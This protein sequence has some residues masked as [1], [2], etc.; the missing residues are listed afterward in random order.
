MARNCFM[1]FAWRHNLIY[2][3]FLLLWILLRRANTFLLSKFFN[4]SKNILFTL[5]MFFGEFSTCLIIYFY[6]KRFLKNKNNNSDNEDTK[7]SL[8]F[9]GMQIN[10]LDSNIKIGF[11]IFVAAYFDFVEFNLSTNYIPKFPN[12]SGSLD[13]RLGGILTIISALFFHFLLKFPILRHQFFS[14]YIIALCFIVSILLEYYFQDVDIFIN[15]WDLSF[16]I[17]FIIIEQ[18]FHALLDSIEKYVVEYNKL[19]HFKVCALEG[20]FGTVITFLY[21]F[22]DN[23]FI[24]QI[25]RIYYEKSGAVF[26]LF[27]F[28]LFVYTVLCGLKNAYRVITNK[29]FSPMTKSLTDYFLNPL[30]LIQNYLEG[31]FKSGGKQNFIYF[32]ISFIL[33]IITDLFGSVF[34]EIII[35]F[36]CDLEIN[37]HDQVCFRSST[38][39]LQEL[40]EMNTI[41]EDDDEYEEDNHN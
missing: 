24:I 40:S 32:L 6:Q 33:G 19:N 15:Y 7:N 20:F 30:F 31:D 5:L 21:L 23:S 28:L 18:F 34:N 41:G 27:I 10:T 29:I 8:I 26:A 36:F 25:N 1:K 39:Y 12:S 2:P 37:T 22:I 17:L 14:L 13:L 38:I 16:K 3:I 4:F 35:L 9:N 11:L